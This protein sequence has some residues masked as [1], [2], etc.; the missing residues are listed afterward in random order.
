GVE[1]VPTDAAV[2]DSEPVACE[3]DAKIAKPTK[4]RKK[5]GNDEDGD[6]EISLKKRR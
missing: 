6:E 5:G 4:K 1:V 2:G 3:K